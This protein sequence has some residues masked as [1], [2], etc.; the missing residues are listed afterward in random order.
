V[1]TYIKD[2]TEIADPPIVV[3]LREHGLLHV[4]EPEVLVDAAATTRLATEMTKIITWGSIP[5]SEAMRLASSTSRCAGPKAHT[6]AA[7]CASAYLGLISVLVPHAVPYRG[8]AEWLKA[9]D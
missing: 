3:G 1:P 9:P 2:R 6:L 8:M 5:S 7:V 4:L